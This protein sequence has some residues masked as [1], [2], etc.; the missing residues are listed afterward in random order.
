MASVYDLRGRLVKTLS[1]SPAGARILWD[2]HDKNGNAFSPG[3]YPFVLRRPGA[4]KKFAGN[5][6]IVP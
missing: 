6:V 3:V 4:Q 5:I 2:G 1:A